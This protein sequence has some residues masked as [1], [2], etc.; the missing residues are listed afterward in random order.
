MK[1]TALTSK[2][3]SCEYAVVIC[4]IG[5]DK[6]TSQISSEPSHI[7]VQDISK[8][9]HPAKTTQS[10]LCGSGSTFR[11]IQVQKA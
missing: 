2:Q 10:K 3:K 4:A 5:F 7:P 1:L 11:F 6:T 8:L 9:G